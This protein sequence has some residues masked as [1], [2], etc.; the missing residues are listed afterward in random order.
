METTW[1]MVSIEINEMTALEAFLTNYFVK[2]FFIRYSFNAKMSTMKPIFTDDTLQHDVIHRIIRVWIL[3]AA[4]TVKS[5]E[6]VVVAVVI[7]RLL[8]GAQLAR[9]YATEL[10]VSTVTAEIPLCVQL[11]ELVTIVACQ[12]AGKTDTS[13]LKVNSDACGTSIQ[14]LT[15]QVA[16]IQYTVTC[17]PL[18]TQHQH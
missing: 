2:V 7:Q 17:T 9:Y 16:L 5:S 8:V 15:L 1:K 3:F 14:C 4:S 10:A 12:A 6:V 11:C 18:H 13:W